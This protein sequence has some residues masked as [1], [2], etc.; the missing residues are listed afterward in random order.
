MGQ[1]FDQA[2]VIVAAGASITTGA[3]SASV[4]IPTMSSGEVARYIRIVALNPCHVRLGAAGITATASDTLVQPADSLVL[5]VPSG[6]T[7]IAA[8][9]DAAAGK[10]QISPLENM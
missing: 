8:I 6:V 2:I 3:A 4:S 5:M 7:T 9:Q 1:R 10:V